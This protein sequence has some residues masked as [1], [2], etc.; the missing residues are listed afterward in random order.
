MQVFDPCSYFLALARNDFARRV[1]LEL[2]EQQQT[3]KGSEVKV[4]AFRLC[5][6]VHRVGCYCALPRFWRCA[7]CRFSIAVDKQAGETH[8]WLKDEISGFRQDL[9]L[10]MPTRFSALQSVDFVIRVVQAHRITDGFWS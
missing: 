9:R 3:R 5:V 6:R 8:I 4:G 2:H 7:P 1:R 10:C